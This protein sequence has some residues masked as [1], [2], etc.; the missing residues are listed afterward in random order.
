MENEKWSLVWTN[1]M[2]LG[3][4]APIAQYP[5]TPQSSCIMMHDIH[6]HIW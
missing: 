2:R 4:N 3:K 1:D 6:P 5:T